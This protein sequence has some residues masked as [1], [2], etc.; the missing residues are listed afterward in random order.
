MQKLTF[1][2][3]QSLS[4]NDIVYEF[5]EPIIDFIKIPPD[6]NKKPLFDRFVNGECEKIIDSMTQDEF[7]FFYRTSIF[8]ERYKNM[9]ISMLEFMTLIYEIWLNE[10]TSIREAFY[11]TQLEIKAKYPQPYYWGEFILV[12]E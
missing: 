12:G 8:Q 1:E 3:L 9:I 11:K 7:D 4:C 2:S 6:S 5:K 10:K